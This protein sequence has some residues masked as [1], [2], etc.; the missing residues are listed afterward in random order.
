MVRTCSS[1]QQDGQ[2]PETWDLAPAKLKY[3]GSGSSPHSL[4]VSDGR[5]WQFLL[6]FCS[7][8]DL[9]LPAEPGSLYLLQH[10]N[11]LGPNNSALSATVL[12]LWLGNEQWWE[13]QITG[14]E[15]QWQA[16]LV[17]AVTEPPPAA[18]MM[19]GTCPL[20]GTGSGIMSPRWA[21][22]SNT[23]LG[24]VGRITLLA[25]WG[26]ALR[27]LFFAFLNAKVHLWIKREHFIYQ[28]PTP[29]QE[30]QGTVSHVF[31][32]AFSIGKFLNITNVVFADGGKRRN[33]QELHK[34]PLFLSLR[35]NTLPVVCCRSFQ[36]L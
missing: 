17:R 31:L 12:W 9:T 27:P 28:A 26:V 3:P 6:L 16:S 19:R 4:G 36:K 2:T 15:S 23:A 29:C 35:E 24:S 34:L 32:T 20:K 11:I 14:E 30:L 5:C 13:L 1:K 33:N 22:G 8:P 21:W 10:Y 25:G 7:Y 18:W